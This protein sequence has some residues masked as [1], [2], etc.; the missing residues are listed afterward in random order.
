MLFRCIIASLQIP[1][2]RQHLRRGERSSIHALRKLSV[3][4]K[5]QMNAKKSI[6]TLLL[7]IGIVALIVFAIADRIGIGENPGFGSVQIAGVII[8]AVAAI[9]GLFFLCKRNPAAAD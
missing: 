7:V 3:K 9:V 4:E 1:K 8:G 5:G 6:G 2:N